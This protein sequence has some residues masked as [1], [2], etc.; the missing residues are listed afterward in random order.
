VQAVVAHALGHLAVDVRREPVRRLARFLVD[1]DLL[2]Q[3]AGAG[4]QLELPG[5]V[6]EL[7]DP[8]ACGVRIVR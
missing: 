1:H 4:A 8:P 3:R 5:A 2:G 7:H 6:G